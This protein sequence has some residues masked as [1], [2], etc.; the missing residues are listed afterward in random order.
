MQTS[1]NMFFLGPDVKH[2]LDFW[3]H[4]SHDNGDYVAPSYLKVIWHRNDS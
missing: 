4:V 3:P 1:V 2:G